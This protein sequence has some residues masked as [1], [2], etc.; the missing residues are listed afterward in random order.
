MQRLPFNR[1]GRAI[2]RKSMRHS[3]VRRSLYVSLFYVAGHAFYY[4][5]IV[6]ANSRLGPVD[7]GRFYLGWAILNIIAAPGAV[8]TLALSGHFAE[9]YRMYGPAK[10]ASALRAALTTLLPWLLAI[11][12]AVEIALLFSGLAFGSDALIM[13]ALLPLA[14]LS[15]VLVDMVRAVFQGALQFVWFG[16]SWLLWCISQFVFGAVLLL[17]IG[18]PWAVFA[19][20]LAANCLAL[21][22]VLVAVWRLRADAARA[23]GGPVAHSE[24]AT[25]SLRYI[26][27]FCTA[28]G[29]FVFLNYVDILVTYL[30]FSGAELGTYAA[31]AV[32]PKAIV[33]ATQPVTQVILPVATH[34]RGQNLKTR[35]A[36]LKAI[37]LTFALA[38]LGATALWL[39]SGEVCGSYYYGIKF[40]N[41][42]IMPLLAS[43]AVAVAVTRTAIIADL[44]NGRYWRPHLPI[45][46]LLLFAAGIWLGRLS[47]T[48]LAM[49]YSIVC[50]LLLCTLV[51]LKFLDWHR[52]G[53]GPF[54][55]R[56]M[57]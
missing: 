57:K 21:G 41:P 31:S 9:V 1:L 37:G 8:L 26:L 44:V 56:T 15:S 16:A 11:V 43:A 47:G 36:L 23:G 4:F 40:C 49:R 20:M 30:K 33:T 12:A 29:A 39:V 46:A 54:L 51:A 18:A 2:G 13:I 3:V 35:E 50:W 5:L 25:Q 48:A 55:K 32:L 14:A 17:L 22:C 6:F 53:D 52:A 38:A 7:F 24:F 45:A 28:L 27:P 19:G 10:V 42:S 34:I